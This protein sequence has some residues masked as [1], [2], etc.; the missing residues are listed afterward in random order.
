MAEQKGSFTL[1][2]LAPSTSTSPTVQKKGQ[3]SFDDLQSAPTM[4]TSKVYNDPSLKPDVLDSGSVANIANPIDSALGNN[5]TS[6]PRSILNLAGA[7]GEGAEKAL[8]IDPNNQLKSAGKMVLGTINSA[9]TGK[10][11]PNAQAQN[12]SLSELTAPLQP[13][14]EAAQGIRENDPDKFTSGLGGVGV[15][16]LPVV[17]GAKGLAEQAW[18]KATALPPQFDPSKP[19]TQFPQSNPPQFAAKLAK[20]S[21]GEK[22]YWLR[23]KLENTVQ[24][25]AP[26]LKHAEASI[27]NGP[28]KNTEEYYRILPAAKDNVWNEYKQY[29][30]HGTPIKGD[31][32]VQRASQGVDKGTIANHPQEYQQF[33]QQMKDKYSG[34][35]FTPEEAQQMLSSLNS[36]A[37]TFY[38]QSNI[39]RASG[40][41]LMA[42]AKWEA[43]A[44]ALRGL[45]DQHIPQGGGAVRQRF[46][47]LSELQEEMPSPSE[48]GEGAIKGISKKAVGAMSTRPGYALL[49]G[50]ARYLGQTSSDSLIRQAF[51]EMPYSGNPTTNPSHPMLPSKPI[52]ANQPLAQNPHPLAVSDVMNGVKTGTP[53]P[54]KAD[55]F[56]NTQHPL[57][58]GNIPQVS[59][60]RSGLLGHPM[61]ALPNVN[62]LYGKVPVQSEPVNPIANSQPRPTLA[63][64]LPVTQNHPKLPISDTSNPISA[65]TPGHPM[66]GLPVSQQHPLLPVEN[67][68]NPV[69]SSQPRPALPTPLNVNQQHPRLPVENQV[70]PINPSQP[71]PQQGNG[72]PVGSSPH[73]TVSAVPNSEPVGPPTSLSSSDVRYSNPVT[74]EPPTA[75]QGV[76]TGLPRQLPPPHL[77]EQVGKDLKLRK[78][79]K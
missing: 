58:S 1:D 75:Q 59:Q 3:F 2:D 79:A 32:L 74:Q 46:G 56:E 71:P 12:P 73:Q 7:V 20:A 6:V 49:R 36:E 8:G 52:S 51:K 9:L 72:W 25:A 22:A 40:S 66:T 28:V 65:S 55:P 14:K 42:T 15:A 68:T 57:E 29:L 33:V 69:A 31:E 37:K 43:P 67:S 78:K 45:I 70:N 50:A 63:T 54:F 60:V 11:D 30:D 77:L 26:D 4:P 39:D 34:K 47:N 19:K 13:A 21:G 48:E 23:D 24:A 18:Q 76:K 5:K 38:K 62:Q 41:K 61:E 16:T 64:P 53:Q 44:D 10:T 27:L 17:E 35:T